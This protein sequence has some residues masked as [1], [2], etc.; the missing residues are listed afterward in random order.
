MSETIDDFDIVTEFFNTKTALGF[1]QGQQRV[2]LLYA[3]YLII[4][5]EHS[6]KVCTS[7]L[8]SASELKRVVSNIRMANK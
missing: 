3:E 2:L 6:D 5:I 8:A 1:M 4:D 7:V